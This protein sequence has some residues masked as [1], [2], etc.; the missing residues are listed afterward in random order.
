MPTYHH[1]RRWVYTNGGESTLT[2]VQEISLNYHIRQVN[3]SC[4]V[5]N[6]QTVF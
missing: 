6:S 5:I 1:I 2:K 3:R 4:H